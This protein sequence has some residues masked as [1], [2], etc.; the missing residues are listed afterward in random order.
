MTTLSIHDY[1]RVPWMDLYSTDVDFPGAA[2]NII[3]TEELGGWKTL[4]FTVARWID[5]DGQR[6]ENPCLA[7]IKNEYLVRYQEDGFVDWY[8]ITLPVDEHEDSNTLAVTCGHISSLLN[9]KKLYLVLDDTNGI[10]TAQQIASVI[11]QNTSWS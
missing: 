1:E 5:Q 6:V 10:G 9:R 3:V 7:F 4:S 8:L 11:L 2:Y